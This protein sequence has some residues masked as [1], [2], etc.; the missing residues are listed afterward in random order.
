MP[1]EVRRRLQPAV[2]QLVAQDDA[3]HALLARAAATA[4][5]DDGEAVV[6]RVLEQLDEGPYL[7]ELAHLQHTR[8]WAHCPPL[9]RWRQPRRAPTSAH[10]G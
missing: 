1:A 5:R 2:A 10:A 8:W 7:L 6:A 4:A 3:E 9:F